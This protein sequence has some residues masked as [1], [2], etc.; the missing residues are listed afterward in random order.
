[1]SRKWR[2]LAWLF[3]TIGCFI[4]MLIGFDWKVSISV[5]IVVGFVCGLINELIQILR[6]RLP[7]LEDKK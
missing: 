3:Y 5:S 1:M 2:L 4:V 6:K 7:E